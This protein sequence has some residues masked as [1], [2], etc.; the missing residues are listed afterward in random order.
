MGVFEL[1]LVAVGLSMDAFAVS[2]CIGLSLP[3]INIKKS[4]IVGGYFGFFQFAMPV[5]GYTAAALFAGKI[6]DYGNW[7]AFGI[8]CFLG[9][10][11][12]AGAV[13]KDES[14]KIEVFPGPKKMIPFAVATSIDALAVGVSFAF[15]EISIVPAALF[16]G[17][18]TFLISIAGVKA[19]NI[20]GA[21][22]KAKA[23]VAGG[24]ILILIG[25]K[26]LFGHLGIFK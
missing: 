25:L 12:I 5:S 10:K 13:K 26:I 19:G 23:E 20:F 1:F 4:A 24:V 9:V 16:I 14:P 3:Q 2:V 21:K 17:V 18:T 6:T 11:T 8:L 15:L 7:I 22:F